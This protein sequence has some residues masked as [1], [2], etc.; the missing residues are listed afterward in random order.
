MTR[1][2]PDLTSTHAAAMMETLKAIWD[3]WRLLPAENRLP[4]IEQKEGIEKNRSPSF[5]GSMH[6]T[7]VEAIARFAP[8]SQTES[9]W[10]E[11]CSHE[12]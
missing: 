11:G 9:P 2:T 10:A 4:Q 12:Q 6:N 3:R 7:I 5:L 1:Y 8:P